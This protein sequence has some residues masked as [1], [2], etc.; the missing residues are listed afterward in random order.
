MFYTQSGVRVLYLVR[1]LYPVRSPWSAI[2]SPWFILT[3][4]VISI[5]DSAFGFEL[6]STHNHLSLR[7]VV[8][9]GKND[10]WRPVWLQQVKLSFKKSVKG[11]FLDFQLSIPLIKTGKPAR[12]MIIFSLTNLSR[13]VYTRVYSVNLMCTIA[14]IKCCL[15]DTFPNK[16]QSYRLLTFSTAWWSAHPQSQHSARSA[17]CRY[18]VISSSQNKE[19]NLESH[20]TVLRTANLLSLSF[21][22]LWTNDY[23][24]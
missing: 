12:A 9:S 13:V 5:R 16:H 24:P 20:A 18:D 21:P 22:R 3:A 4:F 23:H 19:H 15:E 17:S 8:E 2:R 14:S 11:R 6:L 7:Q 10:N 1:V